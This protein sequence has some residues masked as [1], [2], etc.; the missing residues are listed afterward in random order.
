MSTVRPATGADA[1]GIAAVHVGAWQVGYRELLP[2]PVLDA[3]TIDER[4]ETW[5]GHLTDPANDVRTIVADDEGEII[6]FISLVGHARDDDAK[7]GTAEIPALYVHPTRWRTGTGLELMLVALSALRA[8][9]AD[10]V[11]LWVIAANDRAR[12]FFERCGFGPDGA[13]RTG[14]FGER[15]LRYR[16]TL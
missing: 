1:R 9:G 15:E 8:A 5:R 16:L 3:L 14:R 6:G 7:P 10:D 2:Q 4:E 11:A 12:G 13:A